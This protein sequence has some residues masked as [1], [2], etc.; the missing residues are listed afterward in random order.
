MLSSLHVTGQGAHRSIRR[1]LTHLWSVS[2]YLSEEPRP[3]LGI[4]LAQPQTSSGQRT[5]TNLSLS[6]AQL[7][8]TTCSPTAPASAP[9]SREQDRGTQQSALLES[10]LLRYGVSWNGHEAGKQT[11]GT[12]S[13][14]SWGAVGADT[15]GVLGVKGRRV[16]HHG[17]MSKAVDSAVPLATSAVA[18]ELLPEEGSG[19][20]KKQKKRHGKERRCG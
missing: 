14:S 11:A 5:P 3:G 19:S 13:S 4:K 2:W 20:G 9:V 12:S 6:D 15:Q 1:L 18:Y 10:T 17:S 7:P 8:I 16:S